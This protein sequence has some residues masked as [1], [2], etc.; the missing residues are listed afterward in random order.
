M[1][2][3]KG[4]RSFPSLAF[5]DAEGNVIGEPASRTVQSF[6]ETLVLLSAHTK[7][8]ARIKA[9]E[10]GLEFELFIAEYNLGKIS[11]QAAVRKA[12]GFE[13]LTAAQKKQVAQLIL[14]EEVRGLTKRGMSDE[15][16]LPEVSKRFVELLDAGTLPSKTLILDFWAI[17]T[18]TSEKDGDAALLGRCI[19][20]IRSGFPDRR[21]VQDWANELEKKQKALSK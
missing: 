12:N 3:E 4:F 5:L 17:L 18:Y 19:A 7:L 16:T 11:G 9:G 13:G 21:D 2:G 8:I 20:E 6:D 14:D 15:D 10:K 1:L